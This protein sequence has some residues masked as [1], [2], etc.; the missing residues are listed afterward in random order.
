MLAD[1]TAY[2]AA[3]TR[4]EGNELNGWVDAKEPQCGKQ[5]TIIEVFP[6]DKTLTIKFEDDQSF[7]FPNE[8]VGRQMTRTC[9]KVCPETWNEDFIKDFCGE[10]L[11]YSDE[12]I[13]ILVAKIPLNQY[14]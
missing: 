2:K 5:G 4:F 13:S 14:P 12:F 9:D 1:M 7:D 6:Y 3:F 11:G 10:E 8:A